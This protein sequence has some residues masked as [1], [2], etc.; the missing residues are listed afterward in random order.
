[1]G[2]ALNIP[3]LWKLMT[4]APRGELLPPGAIRPEF[5]GEDPFIYTSDLGCLDAPY[6]M[7]A[8]GCAA[9]DAPG[10]AFRISCFRREWA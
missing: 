3:P 6:V 5:F 7:H 8:G 10:I 1:M 9:G 2:S 4:H